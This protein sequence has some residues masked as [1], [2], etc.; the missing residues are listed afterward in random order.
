MDISQTLTIAAEIQQSLLPESCPKL[1]HFDLAAV[2]IPVD[3]V[4][5]DFYD[6]IQ[7]EE[8]RLGILIGDATGHGLSAAIFM[9]AAKSQLLYEAK[10][11]LSPATVMTA[12]HSRV[13]NSFASQSKFAVVTYGILF[14]RDHQFVVT[15]AGM[16]P[17]WVRTKR[18]ECLE[19]QSPGAT[20]PLGSRLMRGEYETRKIALSSEDILVFYS[21]GL[22]E[23]ENQQEELFGYERLADL[24]LSHRKDTAFGI[25]SALITAM[26]D[27]ANVV[28]LDD[29]L[30]LV[31]LKAAPPPDIP[32]VAERSTIQGE[33]KPVAVM[34][35][36]LVDKSGEA[37]DV[38]QIF[39]SAGNT[40]YD[41][42]L[43]A[44]LDD[45][46][47][48]VFE[49][50]SERSL[51]GLFG[52]PQ[53]YEDNAQRALAAAWELK[54]RLAEAD[55]S[56][57][58]GIHTGTV[59][60]RPDAAIDYSLMGE[61]FNHAL[62]LSHN[63]SEGQILLSEHAH[64]LARGTFEVE[65][66]D[67]L[68]IG[69][70]TVLAVKQPA[71]IQSQLRETALV[72]RT[73]ELASLHQCLNRLTVGQGQIV[74]IIGEAG[75]GKSRLV[76]ELK[77]YLGGQGA[78][79][80]QGR[81]TSIGQ[82]VSYRAFLDILRT[83][84]N[85]GEEDSEKEIALKVTESVTNLCPQ[86]AM[87]FLPFLGNLL[88]IKFGNELDDRLMFTTPEQIRHQTL[89]RLREFFGIL[90][91]Q[92]PLM[93]V[94]EDLH[95]SDDLSLDLLSLLMDELATTPLMLLCVYRPEKER[96]I[97]QLSSQAQRKC[98]DRYT[99]IQLQP[100]S[101]LQSRQLMEELLQIKNLP[102]NIKD[103]ILQKSEG[104]PFFIEEVVRSLRE[105]D[106]VS[107]DKE[108]FE[109]LPEIASIDVP[110]TIQSIVLARVDRLPTG[111]KHMLQ[112][113]SVIGRLFKY[114]LLQHL[115]QQE[116]HLD[117]YLNELE[118]REF[119]FV[120][121]KE[122]S[123]KEG[124]LKG[125]TLGVPFNKER[126]VPELEYAFKHALTQEAT[127][128]SMLQRHRIELHHQVAVGI[129]T[130][131]QER[132][133]DYYEELAHHYSMSENAEKAVEYLLKAGEKAKRSYANE[134][135]IVHFTKGLELLKTLPETP[136]RARRELDL[137]IALGTPLIAAKGN[138]AP[139][140]GATYARARELCEQVGET[141][142]LFQVVLGLRR[143]YFARGELLT[144][145]QMSEELCVLARGV[146]D[147]TYF[148]RAH[149]MLT[150]T[151]YCLGKFTQAREQCEQVDAIYDPKQQHSQVLLYG[152]DWGIVRI[153]EACTLWHLGYP[154]QALGMSNEALACAQELSHPFNLAFA[155]FFTA[156][157]H[158]FRRE[159]QV[160][161]E[162]AEASTQLSTEHG[163]PLWMAWGTFLQSWSLAEQGQ[164][165]DSITQMCQ[166]L[167]ACSAMGSEMY[168]TYLLSLLAEM[169]GKVG[170]A[171]EGLTL[172]AEA[173]AVAHKNGERY[174]E[175]ELYRLKG[176]LLLQSE[177]E[178]DAEACFRQAIEIARRQ[179]AKSLELRAAMS[180]SRLWQ[181]QGKKEE[182]RTLLQEIYDWFTEGFDTA[183]LREA[184]A[185]LEALS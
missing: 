127:Y 18:A 49:P 84:F 91:K 45:T 98:L 41:G 175:A 63:A 57:H 148:S 111:A 32:T 79:W 112:C 149:F 55:L 11:T 92:Q 130:L 28:P 39:S 107:Q 182:A 89:M 166:S 72:G 82:S 76:T 134:A 88:S 16:M 178:S 165:N 25:V 83:Y 67:I 106:L 80:L 42:S 136:E 183:D 71:V 81:C 142:Q 74:S 154:D 177:D 61:T 6:F 168:K 159:V 184:K 143:F 126:T 68:D 114:R 23:A 124:V 152:T 1:S 138:A 34:I 132:L 139:E 131:Y 109:A 99:E 147:S 180:L 27:F 161:Q 120:A 64:R 164:V 174:R 2:S 173:L 151:L 62:Q 101:S 160:V 70:G 50:L 135:A 176:E 47:G 10:R 35:C 125:E 66:T 172:L 85:L 170:Q 48:G 179:Q 155:L 20:F 115:T 59:I 15:T 110:D 73:A 90:G 156:Q 9:A 104:N 185:L 33:R 121:N 65:T 7:L 144:A 158:Q 4:G 58:A 116:R 123:L 169:Y 37:V 118:A 38:Q 97:S 141:S 30:T 181:K 93:L 3:K 46:Y 52:V 96:R 103:L 100:L 95:W 137:Q 60:F 162:R 8:D 44:A 167:T 54:A 29:D 53:T 108:H 36:H 56:I 94:L 40:L 87:D 119:I 17:Y 12:A 146:Q 78:N 51:V 31:V 22:V 102:E 171:K 26:A 21:D 128:Q 86:S 75:I 145:H 69:L 43:L 157:I 150:E 24:L 77:T 113:A 163:F 19:L 13:V 105:Q 117:G 122:Y 153:Y 5:G 140:V 129:E 133:E 14:Q